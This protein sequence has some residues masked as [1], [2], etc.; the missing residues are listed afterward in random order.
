MNAWRFNEP[1]DG[2]LVIELKERVLTSKNHGNIGKSM[3]D[4]LIVLR[5]PRKGS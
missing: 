4:L 3:T 1:P 5:C 2:L